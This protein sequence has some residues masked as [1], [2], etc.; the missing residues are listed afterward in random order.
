MPRRS[1][2]PAK[3][4]MKRRPLTPTF[5]FAATLACVST[6]PIAQ[7][8]ASD[9]PPATSDA[10][11][12]QLVTSND[13]AAVYTKAFWRRPQPDDKI[14]QAE[15][16]EWL[17]TSGKVTRWQWF[18]VVEPSPETQAWLA[19]NPFNLSPAADATV[20]APPTWFPEN[21]DRHLL[22]RS[23]GHLLLARSPDDQRLY[24]TD[25]GAGFTP[26]ATP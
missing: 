8:A 1:R 20:D 9:F 10:P 7:A 23:A 4:N 3:P 5:L 11:A 21:L 2:R 12:P 25:S 6:L 17:D 14:L 24:A 15:R 16:R 13:P 19:T 18:L 22:Q 26:A